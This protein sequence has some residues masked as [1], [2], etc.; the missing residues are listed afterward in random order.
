MNRW[1]VPL[2]I[3][4]AVGLIASLASLLLLRQL[5][6][7]ADLDPQ[8]AVTGLRIPPFSL[9]DQD[10]RPV[11]ESIFDGR[12]TILDFIFT[13][14]PF[15]CPGMNMTMAE[16]HRELRGVDVQFVSISVD[17]THDTPAVLKQYGL[18]HEAD[19]SRWRFLT[20]EPGESA[21]VA[22]EGLLFEVAPD[23]ARPIGMAD[24]STMDNII[25]PAQLILVGP[26]RAVLGLYLYDE[27]TQKL[28]IAERARAIAAD[29]HRTPIG[30]IAIISAAAMALGIG[31]IVLVGKKRRALAPAS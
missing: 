19:F 2:T 20:G 6:P 30:L 15:V 8:R 21:R 27:P 28:A 4:A 22:R 9:V 17:P 23:P 25:H 18:N 14:C 31:A 26:D 3:F 10:G 24:G 7:R 13:N 11:S 5:G 29:A 1:L 16:L 12:V